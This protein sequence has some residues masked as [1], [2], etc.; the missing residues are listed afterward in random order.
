MPKPEVARSD[1]HGLGR[2]R[3]IRALELETPSSAAT[4]QQQVQLGPPLRGIEVCFAGTMRDQRLFQRET[5]PT[6]AVARMHGQI[7]R[8]LDTQVVV[9]NA[10]VPEIYLRRFDQPLAEVFEPRR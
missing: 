9:Q 8:V 10:A 6:R 2:S 5:L 7:D 3:R 1:M 4:K